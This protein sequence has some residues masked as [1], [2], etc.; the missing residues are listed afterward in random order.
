MSHKLKYAP[1]ARAAYDHFIYERQR[2]KR[3]D[4]AVGLL[5]IVTALLIGSLPLIVWL[6]DMVP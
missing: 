1:R 2:E 6:G 3:L 5:V 4:F